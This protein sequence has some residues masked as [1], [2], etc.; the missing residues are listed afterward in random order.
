VISF[1]FG[2]IGVEVGGAEAADSAGAMG[3]DIVESGS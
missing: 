3:W 2:M 1:G